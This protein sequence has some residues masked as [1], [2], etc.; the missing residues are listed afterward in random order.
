MIKK[1]SRKFSLTGHEV[2]ALILMLGFASGGLV[3]GWL[4][5]T[6][7][8]APYDYSAEEKLFRQLI[9]GEYPQNK[10]EIMTGDID[11]LSDVSEFNKDNLKK[12]KPDKLESGQKIDINTADLQTLCL[13]PGIG[14]KTAERIIELRNRI[15]KF[16][17]V[18]QLL[19]VKGIGDRK[20]EQIKPYLS[21]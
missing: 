18:S 19:S 5:T 11:S 7:Q 14:E 17:S 13:L 20:L 21:F 16:T 1:L 9:S 15:G 6:P 2:I 3:L 8:P 10:Q 4:N 12:K